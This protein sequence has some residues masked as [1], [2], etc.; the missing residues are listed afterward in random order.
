MPDEISRAREIKML[1]RQEPLGLSILEISRRLNIGRN[2]TAKYL[3]MLYAAGQVDLRRV[4]AAKLYTLAHRVPVSALLGLTSDL[5]VVLDRNLRVVLANDA[6]Q[7]LLRPDRTELVG[8]R[9]AFLRIASSAG[10]RGRP[11][12]LRGGGRVRDP[13]KADGRTVQFT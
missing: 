3:S 10:D 6:F 1:L 8:R 2:V 11:V 4:A 13:W 12:A 9:S 7:A 5:I